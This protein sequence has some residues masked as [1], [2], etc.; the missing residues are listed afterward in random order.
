[1]KNQL[2]RLRCYDISGLHFLE[3]L[4]EKVTAVHIKMPAVMCNALDV[5]PSRGQLVDYIIG[6]LVGN[7]HLLP[8]ISA[9]LQ[10]YDPR[11]N[12]FPLTKSDR[13]NNQI[14]CRSFAPMTIIRMMYNSSIL[15]VINRI[16][17]SKSEDSFDARL[18]RYFISRRGSTLNLVNNQI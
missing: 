17:A 10:R 1:M 14:I 8:G 15:I 9:S 2:S 3:Q 11:F 13:S 7:H 6:S 4:P 5:E 16:V 18:G 12:S